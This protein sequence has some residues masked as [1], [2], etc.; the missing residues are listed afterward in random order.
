MA[1]LFSGE[2]INTALRDHEDSIENHSRELGKIQTVLQDKVDSATFSTQLEQV[3][4]VA[5]DRLGAATLEWGRQ[6]A[7]LQER[8]AALEEREQALCAALATKA[9]A[10]LLESREQHLAACIGALEAQHEELKST[11]AGKADGLHVEEQ[12]RELGALAGR[13]NSLQQVHECLDAKVSTKAD[14]AHLDEQKA[15]ASDL[16]SALKRQGEELSSALQM[17]AS[18]NQHVALDGSLA[19]LQ[20]KLVALE[21]DLAAKLGDIDA[22]LTKT[23]DV[24][25]FDHKARRL[26]EAYEQLAALERRQAQQHGQ[27]QEA[28]GR[29][30]DK[31]SAAQQLRQHEQLQ[32]A[33]AYKD[34]VAKQMR[35]LQSQLD[36]CRALTVRYHEQTLASLATKVEQEQLEQQWDKVIDHDIRTDI[37]LQR[38]ALQAALR[39]KDQLIDLA[40]RMQADL[41][42][43]LALRGRGPPRLGPLVPPTQPSPRK[44]RTSVKAAT[45]VP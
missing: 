38:E 10:S 5:A 29:K 42:C 26:D 6:V 25:L 7:A 1:I 12:Q 44:L 30:F 9:E 43:A 15:R 17:K 21:K 16:A 32:S 33:C 23:V 37:Q 11:V 28:L 19:G 14:I 8:T 39:K 18:A 34:D 41:G 2:K 31:D 45:P 27:V 4:A 35:Q 22:T 3:G 36:D 40:E 13:L 24:T 20:S